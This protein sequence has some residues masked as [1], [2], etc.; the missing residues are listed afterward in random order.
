MD[1]S[2]SDDFPSSEDV[3][4]APIVTTHMARFEF[5]EHGTKILMVEWLPGAGAATTE[6]DS[7]L[8]E[9]LPEPDSLRESVTGGWHVSWPGK[10]TFLPATDKDQDGSRR[11][12][13]F[14]LPTDASI[15]GTVTISRPGRANIEVKPLPAIFPDGFDFDAGPRGVL[16]TIWARNRLAEL[17]SEMDAE[18]RTNAESVGLEMALAEKQ[19]IID[20]FLPAPPPAAPPPSSTST[21][22]PS[23]PPSPVGGRLGDKLKGLRLATGPADLIPSPTANIFTGVN[24]QSHTL[25]PRGG[26]IAVSGFA[27]MPR[28]KPPTATT[29]LD[30]V[31]KGHVPASQDSQ[32]PEDDLFALPMSPRSPDMK[33]SPFSLL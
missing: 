28:A 16:H 25:S 33:K 32:D 18:L 20:N 6:P 14:L 27:S 5:S 29:S 9:P 13:Y 11:R 23:F 30:A 24:D 17:K 21:T 22:A 4:A 1:P 12:V 19:W 2:T 10:S 3:T 15:P 8:A 7:D 26:D 31:L